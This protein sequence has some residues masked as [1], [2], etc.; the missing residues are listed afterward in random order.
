MQN[1]QLLNTGDAA[2]Y[3]GVA[4]GTLEQW[5]TQT[6]PK[7]PSYVRLGFQVRY[8]ATDLAGW[9]E[10]NVVLLEKGGDND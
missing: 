10:Q 9:I 6:P 3:L 4:R 7:G 1:P 8:R 5:R 2:A